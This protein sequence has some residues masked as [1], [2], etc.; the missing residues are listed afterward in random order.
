MPSPSPHP[1]SLGR[2]CK[3]CGKPFRG[4]PDKKYCGVPCKNR[5][6]HLRRARTR[7]EVKRVD[8]FLH[9]NREILEEVMEGKGKKWTFSRRLIDRMG[10]R[11]TYMTGYYFNKEGKMYR[12]VYDYAWMDFSDQK[13]LVVRRQARLLPP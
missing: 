9:R 10:F 2:N 8:A 12:L 5:F 7:S 1:S 13:I 3:Q 11:F 6:N 4:R